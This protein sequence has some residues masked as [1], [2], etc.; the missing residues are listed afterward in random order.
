MRIGPIRANFGERKRAGIVRG[1]QDKEIS[2]L[3]GKARHSVR[4]GDSDL[5]PERRARSDA[6]Y[7]AGL[8]TD[9]C[10]AM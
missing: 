2:M 8:A 9:R 3:S 1:I 10:L 4:A 6:P 7:H 5:N